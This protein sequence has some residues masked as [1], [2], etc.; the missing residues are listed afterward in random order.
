M[1]KV[2]TKVQGE[3]GQNEKQKMRA[4]WS[5]FHPLWV[6]FN[7]PSDLFT[8]TNVTLGCNICL[9]DNRLF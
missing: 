8:L 5:E 9:M 1:G 2:W 3:K 7:G 6:Q 4:F